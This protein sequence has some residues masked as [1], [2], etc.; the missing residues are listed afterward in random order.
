MCGI[1]GIIEKG[2]NNRELMS[3]M[4]DAIAH[5]GPDDK[6]LFAHGD[7]ILGHR[8]LSIIDLSTGNQPIFNEDKTIAVVYNGEIY[9]FKEIRKELEGRG[10]HF[11]TNSDTEIL[12]HL[13]EEHGPNF[14]DKLNG[15][16]AF[17][18]YDLNEKVLMLG[19]DHFGVKPL[20]YYHKDAVF[21]FGS[22]QKSIILHP[23]YN[24]A[25]NYKA[26]HYHLNL[27][28][29]QS[30]ETLFA[31]IK[32]LPPAHYAVFKNNSLE[33]RPYWKLTPET[34]HTISENEAIEG[35]NF[36]IKQA[37]ERQLI[38]DVPIGVYLSGGLDSSTIVQKMHEIGVPQINT[39]TLGFNEPT[40]EFPD[41]ERIAKAFNTNHHTH[42]LSMNPLG[43]LDKVIWH[44]EEPK[45]NLL[46]GYKMSEFVR[47]QNIKVVLGG[48]G[49]DELFAGYD[50][51]KFIYPFNTWHQNMPRWM[52]KLARIKSDILFK[53]QN[54]S[55]TL[56]FDEYRRGVQ[57]LLSIGQI[58]RFYLIIRNVWDFDEGFYREIYAPEFCDL[59]LKERWQVV[60]EFKPFFDA[61]EK[62]TNAVD[63][64]LFT[65]FQTKMVNDY[66]L[67]NDRMSMANSV[68]ERVPFLDKDLVE[69]GFSLPVQMK[70][71][72]G[73]TKAIFRKAMEDKLP[74]KIITKKKWGFTVNSY[75][76]FKKDLKTEIEKELTPEFIRQ[77][78]IF[79]Y[80]YIRR[81]L[82]YPAHPKLRWHYNYLWVVL[83]Y[84]KWEKM[85]LK[86]NSFHKD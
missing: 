64:V 60:H 33:V 48:L 81:I 79:N 72:H 32:R 46:Q 69:F 30:N 61:L 29:T 11:S 63:A 86:S 49:G 68:E 84:A 26:L 36:H 10:H 43:D 71:N 52:Q 47:S 75:L 6:S 18:I 70:I 16:F 20:H 66:L 19:R 40:D 27:R 12:V 8:R 44:A 37:V 82:D 83:G 39:Y 78:S 56:R 77:Q 54:S 25:V 50:I 67:T 31:G 4:L 23:K 45:I 53:L 5:R 14:V 85:F 7:C 9:N 24:T 1:A 34:N 51:H 62:G 3:Q 15:I 74:P 2:K 38:S 21:L 17:A 65:E 59:I 57:M 22:E 58:E 41:A 28:Y 13:Y 76:Q 42:S 80:S 73:T 35:V 55:R